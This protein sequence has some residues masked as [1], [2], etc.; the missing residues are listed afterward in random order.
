MS[1]V[2]N[3]KLEITKYTIFFLKLTQTSSLLYANCKPNLGYLL[4]FI[5]N[6]F[7]KLRFINK[8]RPISL[9]S[10]GGFLLN[11]IVVNHHSDNL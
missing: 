9:D 11:T 5:Q 7:I 10:A 2:I 3:V 8:S 6:S 1:I 4:A